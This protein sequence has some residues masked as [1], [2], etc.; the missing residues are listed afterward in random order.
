MY[1]YEAKYY[2]KEKSFMLVHHPYEGSYENKEGR[3]VEKYRYKIIF[4]G[5]SESLKKEIDDDWL[6]DDYL[7]NKI[8][9]NWKG[10]KDNVKRVLFRLI[11]DKTDRFIKAD[12]TA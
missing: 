3:K 7:A 4:D 2:P 12:P 9:F 10:N 8:D 6:G 5:R 1:E 11:F